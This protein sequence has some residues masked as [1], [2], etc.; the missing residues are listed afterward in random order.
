MNPEEINSTF[1]EYRHLNSMVYSR[2]SGG[3]LVAQRVQKQSFPSSLQ[4]SVGSTI[5]AIFNINQPVGGPTSYL[6]FAFTSNN[7]TDFGSGS[8]INMIESVRVFHRSGEMLSQ[9]LNISTL[10]KL[11]LLYNTTQSDYVQLAKQIYA[12]NVP[13]SSDV[14]TANLLKNDENVAIIPLSL[15]AEIFG[16]TNQYIPASLISGMRIEIQLTSSVALMGVR[17][18]AALITAITPVFTFDCIQDFDNVKKM[19]IEEQA[20]VQN[21][22]LQFTYDTYFSSSSSSANVSSLNI[23]VLQSA[24]MVEA[25]FLVIRNPIKVNAADATASFD[26]VPFVS[27]AKDGL[28]SYQWRIGSDYK[29]IYTVKNA[30]EAYMLTCQAVNHVYHQNSML[31]HCKGVSVSGFGS[32][33]AV[34]GSSFEKDA[35][36]VV[37]LAGEPTN[38]SRLVNIHV[39]G[40]DDEAQAVGAKAFIFMKYVRIA[41]LMGDSCVV[42][43]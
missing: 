15:I 41:N 4:Y 32:T 23:D 16:N 8:V 36:S 42:D 30:A 43:R 19:L 37:L 31:S 9:C 6:R 7:A 40:L 10:G 27:E 14:G 35:T 34:Y 26:F 29:P 12:N 5:Q 2:N 33:T 11:K 21:S 17:N 28:S 24:S 38:N 20:D 1:N 25:C 39:E 13:G 18:T 3:S 22:G